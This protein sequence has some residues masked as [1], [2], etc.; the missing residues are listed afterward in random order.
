MSSI[1]MG[2]MKELTQEER[3]QIDL[4][5][6]L[7]PDW[8]QKKIADSIKRSPQTIGRYLKDPENYGK[9]KRSGRPRVTTERQDRAI[10]KAAVNE[11]LSLAEIKFQLNLD[12][13]KSTIWT[14]LNY[15]PNITFGRHQAKPVLTERHKVARL[16]FAREMVSTS[17]EKWRNIIWSDEKKWNLDGPDGLKSYWY[18]IR[19]EK[20]VISKR[21]H[22][23]GGVMIWGAFRA[24]KCL[25]IEFCSGKMNSLDYQ[26]ILGEY[27]LP[28]ISASPNAKFVFQQDNAAIHTSR[29][30]K[31]WLESHQIR[32]LPW[33][34][35]SP[36]LNPIENLWGLLVRKIYSHG[37]QFRTISDLKTMIV[38]EWNSI[39][40]ELTDSLVTSMKDRMIKVIE[41]KGGS[42]EY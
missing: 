28:E 2:K 35:L 39:P 37:R 15:D 19:R 32:V 16:N 10:A 29:S 22:G 42:I 34:A 38:N 4:L 14:R 9:S 3:S 36:D 12:C 20:T 33:P 41:A 21:Q 40:Q 30:T 11:K 13:C 8:T 7:H 27:L 6:R 26:G 25:P 24:T 1:R 23:G 17:T 31:L 5:R 18:D